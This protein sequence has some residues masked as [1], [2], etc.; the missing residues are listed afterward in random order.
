MLQSALYEV[1]SPNSG[2]WRRLRRPQGS[3]AVSVSGCAESGS[4][5][6]LHGRCVMLDVG[7][8]ATDLSWALRRSHEWL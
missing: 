8:F 6:G 2:W 7:E 4:R 3:C 5:I 1:S